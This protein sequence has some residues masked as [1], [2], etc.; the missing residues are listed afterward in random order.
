[1]FIGTYSGIETIS[2]TGDCNPLSYTDPCFVWND[3]TWVNDTTEVGNTEYWDE[4]EEINDINGNGILDIGCYD[5]GGNYIND[6]NFDYGNIFKEYSCA[7][8]GLVYSTDYYCSALINNNLIEEGQCL[9]TIEESLVD[10]FTLFNAYPNPFNPI[11]TITYSVKNPGK[12]NIDIY[13]V[14]GQHVYSLIDGYH[15]PGKTYEVIWNS[16]NQSKLPISS[17][18]Y[19]LKAK[20]AE[21]ILIQRITLNK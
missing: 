7:I 11:T 19:L 9:N 12:V 8:S 14:L 15:F 1:M 17:G 13:N 20:S 18:V 5:C 16:D 3:E 6:E 2:C 4:G 10:E 21:N